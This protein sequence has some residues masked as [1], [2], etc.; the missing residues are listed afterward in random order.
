MIR[1]GVIGTGNIVAQMMTTLY[2]ANN[3]ARYAIASRTHS[4]ALLFKGKYNF[5]VAHK[6]YED[7]IHDENVDLVYIAATHDYHYKLA[8]EALLLGKPVFCEKP[9]ACTVEEAEELVN[10]AREKKIFLAEGMWI[11]YQPLFAELKHTLD[12]KELGD[13]VA[14]NCGLCYNIFERE[15]ISSPEMG[16]GAMRDLGIYPIAATTFLLGNDLEVKNS[17]SIYENGV[18]ASDYVIVANKDNQHAMISTSVIAM[19]NCPFTIRCADGYIEMHS[20]GNPGDYIIF[21]MRKGTTSRV[22]SRVN[23]RYEWEA[24]TKAIDAGMIETPEYTH[25][26]ILATLKIAYTALKNGKKQ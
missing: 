26:D 8:K 2:S 12:K 19:D 5:T 14:I 13:I 4:R 6:S 11:R 7:L 18:D 25:D 15:R 16:G 10:I 24:V 22:E 1:L 20:L 21:N 9:L 17:Y 23:Y 3:I